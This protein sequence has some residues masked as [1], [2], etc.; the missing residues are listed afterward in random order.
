MTK[1]GVIPFSCLEDVGARICM[2][3]GMKRKNKAEEVQRK[4]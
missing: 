3:K 1:M 2:G 4:K